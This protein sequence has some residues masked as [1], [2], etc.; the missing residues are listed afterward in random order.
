MPN[1]C[2]CECVRACVYVYKY[3]YGKLLNLGT[4]S[5]LQPY[6]VYKNEI[7]IGHTAFGFNN[8]IDPKKFKIRLSVAT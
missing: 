7:V 4:K 6:E 8:N 1:L 5:S 2:M 3:V